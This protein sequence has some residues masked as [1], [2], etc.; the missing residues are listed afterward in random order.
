MLVKRRLDKGDRVVN[1]K[2]KLGS[3]DLHCLVKWIQARKIVLI[4][5]ITFV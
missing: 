5:A 2:E 4:Q 1:P 3:S